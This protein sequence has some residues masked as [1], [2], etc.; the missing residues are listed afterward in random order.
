MWMG[1]IIL[2]GSIWKLQVNTAPLEPLLI[3]PAG[4]KVVS[5]DNYQD[6]VDKIPQMMSCTFT[7]AVGV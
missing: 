7:K 4:W 2:Q 3:P 5:A 1:P 6:F